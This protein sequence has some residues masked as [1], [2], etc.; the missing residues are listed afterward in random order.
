MD[1]QLAQGS[2]VG[3]RAVPSLPGWQGPGTGTHESRG[4]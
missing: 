4:A 3:T 1:G 2:L